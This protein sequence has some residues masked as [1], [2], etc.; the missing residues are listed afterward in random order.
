MPGAVSC[1]SVFPPQPNHK[2]EEGVLRD[3]TKSNPVC[4]RKDMDTNLCN[5]SLKEQV[6]LWSDSH[7]ISRYAL[8]PMQG[9][10]KLKTTVRQKSK[11]AWQPWTMEPRVAS[12]VFTQ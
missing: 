5:R 3:Q 7:L 4:T 6:P 8:K 9:H 11:G 12:K 10:A 2:T 1:C